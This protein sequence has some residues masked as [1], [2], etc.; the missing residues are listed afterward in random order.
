MD[1]K[2][3]EVAP[4]LYQLYLPL[5][6]RP[7]IVNVYLLR[8]GDEW[9]LFDTG[10]SSEESLAVFAAALAE[11]NCLPTAI[12]TLISTHHH[13]D[14]FGAARR[15]KQLTGAEIY[16]HPLEAQRMNHLLSIQPGA[17]LAFF[18]QHGVPLADGPDA[19]PTPVQV[20]GPTY[21]PTTPDHFMQDGE[22]IRVG[23]REIHVVWTPGHSPGHCCLYLPEEKILIV[24]DHLLPKITPHVGVYPDYPDNPLG[25]FLASQEKVHALEV[26][27]V[28][29]AHG[30]V[31]T[32]H[33][34][35]ARQLIHHHKQRKDEM[36]DLIRRRPKTAHEIAQE[37]FGVDHERPLFHTI[38]ATFETLAHLHLSLYEGRV[39]RIEEEE[40]IRFLAV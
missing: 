14:H 37:V 3:R 12:H 1:S 20:W 39:R 17:S 40:R 2:I 7:S 28:L 29:P 23:R 8:S 16:F 26:A 6:M 9:V 19:L 5:P 21:A 18:R 35:R 27:L 36:L 22:V 11:V 32:D 30:A 15:H 24:G 33:R 13:P 38:A 10:I 25:E 4:D 34:A 31:F